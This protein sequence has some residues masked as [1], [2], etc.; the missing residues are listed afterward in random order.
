MPGGRRSGPE[1]SRPLKA[2][3]SL[4]SRA[5]ASDYLRKG[6]VRCRDVTKCDL[7]PT[8][9]KPRILAELRF[10]FRNTYSAERPQRLLALPEFCQRQTAEN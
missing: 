9:G 2:G 1:R 3:L 7:T 8:N 10:Q 6:G 4:P 5:L